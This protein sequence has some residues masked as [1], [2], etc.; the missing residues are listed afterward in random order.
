[1]MDLHC[2]LISSV[3]FP[4]VR[5][6]VQS[7]QLSMMDLHC[8]KSQ[9]G[10]YTVQRGG[11][12]A[13]SVVWKISAGEQLRQGDFPTVKK[14]V[15]AEQWGVYFIRRFPLVKFQRGNEQCNKGIL[16]CSKCQRGVYTVQR[17]K[18]LR[19]TTRGNAIRQF[20]LYSKISA[21]EQLRADFYK[22]IFSCKD[23]SRARTV[24]SRFYKAISPCKK[25]H[26]G[27]TLFRKFY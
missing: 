24:E 26:D 25:F 18:P 15:Q 13:I 11:Y 6:L 22:A 17:E 27:F 4:A 21:G 12:R 2:S 9:R 14:L 16:R 8:S 23:S 10:V 3:E 7:E 1:M 19:K 20:Q 5:K